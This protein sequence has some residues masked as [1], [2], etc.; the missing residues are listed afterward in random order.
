M[1]N[2]NKKISK[3]VLWTRIFCGLLAFL[4]VAGVAY[5]SVELGIESCKTI[6]AEKEAEKQAA[7]TTTKPK[8]T[9]PKP[10]TTTKA[11]ATSNTPA[12]SAS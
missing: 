9:T 8:V 6:Q 10:V 1:E 3:K 2:N 4:M 12:G 11:P 5:L 7:S